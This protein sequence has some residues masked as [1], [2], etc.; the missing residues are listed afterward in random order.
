MLSYIQNKVSVIDEDTLIR[1]CVSSFTKEEIEKSKSLLFDSIPTAEKLKKRKNKGKEERDMGDIVNLFKTTGPDQ[2]PIFCAR[3]LE[4]LPPVLFDHLDCTKLLKDLLRVKNDL[5]MIQLSYVTQ[6]ELKDLKSELLSNMRY[7]SILPASVCK[8]NNKRGGWVL[9]S[10]P[11]GLSH[12]NTSMD[13]STTDNGEILDQKVSSQQY[14]DI[15]TSDISNCASIELQTPN[16]CCED[17]ETMCKSTATAVSNSQ[18][19]M[20]TSQ[21]QQNSEKTCNNG[22]AMLTTDKRDQGIVFRRSDVLSADSRPVHN[23]ELVDKEGWQKVKSRK[24]SKY[25]FLGTSGINR[26]SEGKFKA[27]ESMVPIFITKIHKETT[28][29]DIKSYVYKNTQEHISLEK[30]SFKHERN[31]NAYKFF[32]KE[33]KVPMFLENKLWPQGIIFR[34]FVNYRRK[35]TNSF[36]EKSTVGPH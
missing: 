24:V 35:L 16:V 25:R 13:E 31:Y 22:V 33:H 30:V 26:D 7:D 10:G 3:N 8:V 15:L 34:K 19:V 5:K 23:D 9:D 32:V 14:R 11:V 12:I 1:I 36:G 20:V 21:Q 4:K 6:N 27:A 28:D 17:S 18:P 2:I 29:T